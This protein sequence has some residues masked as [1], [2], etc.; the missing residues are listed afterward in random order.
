MTGIN[1]KQLSVS[2]V[3]S[4]LL[5]CIATACSSPSVQDR[6]PSRTPAYLD[7]LPD[8]VV[9]ELPRS[10][11]GNRSP[12]TVLGKS[13]TLLPRSEGY[14]AR[15]KASWYGAKFHGRLTSSGERYNMYTLT[16]AHK[17]LPIPCF[18]R[19]TNLDN[20]K[21]TVVR[22]NDR[23]PFHSDRII[24]LSYAAAIKLGYASK[25]TANVKVEVVTPALIASVKRKQYSK[26]VAYTGNTQKTKIVAKNG[27]AFGTRAVSHSAP[28]QYTSKKP[29][30]NV[31]TADSIYLQAGAFSEIKSAS[32]IQNRLE[33]LLGSI[34]QVADSA[35][36]LFRV[37][38][39]PL[40]H[41]REAERIQSLMESA[42]FSRPLI[43]H[44]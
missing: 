10:K 8:P 44:R 29:M 11:S 4:F 21:S 19:V 7:R 17:R 26:P 41:L 22:V 43:L 35:D 39:G 16:A 28:G 13:Y 20:G 3:C 25:G 15:G 33:Q 37:N 27:T 18:A 23:G 5:V 1:T 9:R 14:R 36:G 12:Y 6:A 31:R 2:R 30:Q 24:D 32:A 38:I 42:D 40:E 34:V